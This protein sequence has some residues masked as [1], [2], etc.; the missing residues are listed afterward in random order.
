MI[1]WS[2]S[3]SESQIALLSAMNEFDRWRAANP[4][5]A[6][7]NALNQKSEAYYDASPFAR[8]N[9]FLTHSRGLLRD[10]LL[11]HDTTAA[12]GG[13]WSVTEKG[14]LVLRV[15][16]IEL[17]EMKGRPLLG[18]GIPRTKYHSMAVHVDTARKLKKG[19]EAP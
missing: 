10:G 4:K 5:E 19:K 18:D 2:L 8:F 17:S 6:S 7:A 9:H 3:L 13:E 15:I 11:R 1:Q 16:E 12:K 14:R